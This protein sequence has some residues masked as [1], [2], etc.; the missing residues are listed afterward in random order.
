MTISTTTNQV[1]Y[2]GD[3]ASLA[4]AFPSPFIAMTDLKVYLNGVIQTT[5]YSVAGIAPSGGSGTFANGTVT[6]GVA[7]AAAV[8]ILIY[9]DPDLLQSTSLPPND[10]FPSKTVERAF[11]KLTLIVQRLYGKVSRAILVPDGETGTTLILPAPSVRAGNLVSF[12]SLGNVI[13]SA[14]V[15]GTATALAAD[16]ASSALPTKNSGQIGFLYSLGYSSGTIGRWLQDLATLV[17][18]SFI[19]TIQSGVGAVLRTLQS[20]VRESVTPADFGDITL[21]NAAAVVQASLD[22]CVATARALTL[23]AGAI[24][25]GPLS[26]NGTGHATPADSQWAGVLSVHG[27]GRRASVFL[28]AVGAY[29]PSDYVITAQNLSGVQYS[30]FGI[31]GNGNALNGMNL[32]WVG[33]SNGVPGTA[34][35]NQNVFENL[36]IDGCSAIGFMLDQ[37]HD[38]KISG[39]WVRGVASNGIGFS[40]QGAGGQLAASDVWVSTGLS[41]IACQN[42][43]LVN[44]GFFG[45]VKLT[46]SGYNHIDFTGVHLYPDPATGAIINSTATG[47]ATRGCHFSACYFNAC[48]YA[49]RG[50]FHEGATF[51]ACK[52]QAWTAFADP[53]NFSTA[54]G[55]GNLPVFIF[56]NC[57]FEGA[58]PVGVAGLYHV[59]LIGCRDSS[60]AVISS[61]AAVSYTPVWSASGT[62][63]SLGN[64]TIVGRY[65]RSG[66]MVT[67]QMLLTMGSTTTFGTGGYLFSLPLSAD[68]LTGFNGDL[69]LTDVSAPQGYSGSVFNAS[70]TTIA[71]LTAAA[72]G[73][74]PTVPFTFAVGDTISVS[75]TYITDAV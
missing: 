4:F 17:G 33:G 3:G 67:A 53:A 10:P 54:G 7:P 30:N 56:Q 57:S 73:V 12:D 28:G 51:T 31:N 69:F 61:D 14:P 64:G 11:D 68:S 8:V 23:P 5:G 6:F 34:P 45:G 36:F 70:S 9:C 20:K 15:A 63:V 40:F 41:L 43:A 19:G 62:A 55:S 46:G 27:E 66:K 71:L 48:A 38:S 44:C 75:I 2:A 42:A 26:F 52:F 29:G 60:G 21:A 22:S 35:S 39:L 37:A 49:L 24:T 65:V 47:N 32:S 50:R 16:L 18:S 1:T 59:I 13:V 72:A 58:T 25:T 74:G